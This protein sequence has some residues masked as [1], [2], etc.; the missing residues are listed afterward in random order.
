MLHKAEQVGSMS[1]QRIL[2][3]RQQGG[4]TGS[5]KRQGATI[6]MYHGHTCD[7]TMRILP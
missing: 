7:D 4:A 1:M 2:V 5:L 6:H 3:N